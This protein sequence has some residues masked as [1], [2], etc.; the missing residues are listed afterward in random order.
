[1]LYHFVVKASVFKSPRSRPFEGYGDADP[2]N[3]SALVRG[4]ELRM[5]ETRAVHRAL[6]KAF[7]IPACVEPR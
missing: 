5:A 2:S 3:V 1:M 7:A 6:R 4:A